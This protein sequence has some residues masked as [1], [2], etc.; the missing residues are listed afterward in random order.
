MS[1]NFRVIRFLTSFELFFYLLITSL[2][3]IIPLKFLYKLGLWDIFSLIPSKFFIVLM[4]LNRFF[5]LLYE[6]FI[7]KGNGNN[8]PTSPFT[9]GRQRGI[10]VKWG[11]GEF[12][13]IS[14]GWRSIV[15]AGILIVISGLVLNFA[16]RFEGVVG[17]G[18]GESFIDYDS[19]EKGP[20]SKPLKS[21]FGVKQIEGEPLKLN[22]KTKVEI[23]HDKNKSI[24]LSVGQSARFSSSN[25]K[26]IKVEPAPRFLI[27]DE[28]GKELHSAFVK[29]NL[30][31]QGKEDYFR[32]P[33]VAHRFYLS[34]TGK[35]DKPFNIKIVRG[36]LIIKT[37]DIAPGEEVAFERLKISFPENSK[38]A[39][40]KVSYYPG[41]RVIFAGLIVIVAGIIL[42]RLRKRVAG[43]V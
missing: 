40:I 16:Y 42:L 24:I 5:G 38:W 15:T 30:Y 43:S 12:E 14:S 20:L 17:L 9:K 36:K 35:S 22:K 26:V 31:P 18:E 37:E 1:S 8:P 13:K 19:I 3:V 33:V 10:I 32:S 41:N 4:F 25:V 11:E 6:I 27:A 28:K 7:S 34:L 23:V 39:E 21:S 29:L 2:L